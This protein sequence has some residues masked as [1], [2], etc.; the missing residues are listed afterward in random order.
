[1]NLYLPV[2]LLDYFGQYWKNDGMTNQ[3]T[4]WPTM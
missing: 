4:Q 2:N 1:M 3:T